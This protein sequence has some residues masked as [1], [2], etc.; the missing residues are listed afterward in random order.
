[1][2]ETLPQPKLPRVPQAKQGR[3]KQRKCGSTACRESSQEK[4]MEAVG[5][6][7][8]HAAWTDLLSLSPGVRVPTCTNNHR[9]E[10]RMREIR[11]S[12]LEEGAGLIPRS[13]PYHSP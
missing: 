6:C 3:V 11:P 5:R 10:S 8:L 1:M 12:G 9:L 4:S 2:R 7:L 13:Y